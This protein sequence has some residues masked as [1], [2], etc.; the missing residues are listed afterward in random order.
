[1]FLLGRLAKVQ[2]LKGEF[3]L[4]P[5][6]DD[7][8]RIPRIQGLVLAPPGMDLSHANE[9]GPG[10]QPLVARAFRWQ[11]SRPCVAFEGIEDRASAEAFKGWCLWMPEEQA[12]LEEGESFR[13]DRSRR[14]ENSRGR[15]PDD[16][17]KS[18]SSPKIRA[19]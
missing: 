19:S 1:M 5:L 18:L 15:F 2:G 8:A 4:H 7:P 3:I 13:H 12:H 6:T 9:G 11:Q 16:H 17:F 14:G 10:T